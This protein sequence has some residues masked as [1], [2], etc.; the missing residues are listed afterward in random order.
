MALSRK[1][2]I[3]TAKLKDHAQLHLQANSKNKQKS[4]VTKKYKKKQ[5]PSPQVLVGGHISQ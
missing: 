2:S 3:E 5:Q 1:V 4:C